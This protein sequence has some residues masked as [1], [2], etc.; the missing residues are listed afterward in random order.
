MRNRAKCKL[1]QDI[2][3]SFH[4]QDYVQCK[5]GEISISGGNYD[6]NCAAKDWNNFLRVDDEGNEIV[7]KVLD[8]GKTIPIEAA[9]N[10]LSRKEQIAMLESMVKN[11]E[12]LPHHAM[13][14]PINHADFYAYFLILISILKTSD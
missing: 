13:E 10:K 1:C 3:E 2:L 14:T 9:Q 4:Q 12:N 7:V 8:K 6:L 5:C 11:I